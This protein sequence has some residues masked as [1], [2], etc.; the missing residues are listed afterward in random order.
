[1][2]FIRS[3][4]VFNFVFADV[5]CPLRQAWRDEPG[6]AS[7][8][9]DD[10]GGAGAVRAAAGEEADAAAPRR[11]LPRPPLR[12]GHRHPRL[13]L[14]GPGA[15]AQREGGGT[16]QERDALAGAASVRAAAKGGVE[17]LHRRR[18]QLRR[19]LLAG[20]ATTEFLLLD[21]RIYLAFSPICSD[22]NGEP[23]QV[24][25]PSQPG[26]SGK[27][28]RDVTKLRKIVSRGYTVEIC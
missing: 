25:D 18:R 20:Y 27:R 15:Q 26:A 12:R 2:Q 14:R 16:R 17:R 3:C 4:I 22:P 1:M 8:V 5:R 28:V 10:R 19:L 7:H 23:A 24:Q 11:L 21:F 9:P 13:A 6:D